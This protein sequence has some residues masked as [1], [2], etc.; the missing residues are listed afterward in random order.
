MWFFEWFYKSSFFEKG[1]R[2]DYFVKYQIFFDKKCYKLSQKRFKVSTLGSYTFSDDIL[3]KNE[4]FEISTKKIQFFGKEFLKE[5]GKGGN[6]QIGEC[7]EASDWAIF[8]SFG[9]F[10]MK[11]GT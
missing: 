5:I 7:R 9:D 3:V 2:G 6:G 11:K 10:T 8:V 1:H 4:N